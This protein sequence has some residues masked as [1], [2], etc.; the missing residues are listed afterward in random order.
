MWH[1]IALANRTAL[2]NGLDD[3]EKHLLDLRSAIESGN[4]EYLR[5]LFARAKQARDAFGEM[6]AIRQMKKQSD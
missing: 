4:G 1:D 6:D 3:F 2:L 5:D